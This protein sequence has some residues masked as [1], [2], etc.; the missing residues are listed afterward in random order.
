MTIGCSNQ[1]PGFA[2]VIISSKP[3][4][5]QADRKPGRCQGKASL[6]VSLSQYKRRSPL[7]RRRRSAYFKFIIKY[8]S[9]NSARGCVGKT[10]SSKSP[11]GI[12]IQWQASPI[13]I[14]SKPDGR[15]HLTA[16]RR[17]TSSFKFTITIYLMLYVVSPSRA[18]DT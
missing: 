2:R 13:I 14:K 3:M 10:T 5:L 11:L 15:F 7:D 6:K 17:G 4:Q 12:L 9:A 16:L 8:Y 18:R 1:R